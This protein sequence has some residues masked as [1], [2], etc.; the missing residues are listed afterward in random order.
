MK[1]S[2]LPAILL[3]LI[4]LLPLCAFADGIPV[5][6]FITSTKIP[7]EHQL[8]KEELPPMPTVE[9]TE[10]GYLLTGLSA[11]GVHKSAMVRY[12]FQVDGSALIDE[13]D[14]F[15]D[16]MLFTG[17]LDGL[18]NGVF[19]RLK[20]TSKYYDTVEISFITKPLEK[21][22]TDQDRI[23]MIQFIKKSKCSVQCYR[24]KHYNFTWQS[25]KEYGTATYDAEGILEDVYYNPKK[26]GKNSCTYSLF[27]RTDDLTGEPFYEL[28]LITD[29]DKQKALKKIPVTLVS[30]P[31]V[32]IK[33]PEGEN[34]DLQA[35]RSW[36][37]G[38][39]VSREDTVPQAFPFSGLT[40][41]DSPEV[42]CEYRDGEYVYTLKHLY[43]W[44]AR[45]SCLGLTYLAKDPKEA[46]DWFFAEDVESA[47][48]PEPGDTRLISRNENGTFDFYVTSE[49]EYINHLTMSGRAEKD[50]ETDEITG[51]QTEFTIHLDYTSPLTIRNIPGEDSVEKELTWQPDDNHTIVA[52]YR[53]DLLAGYTAS[54]VENSAIYRWGVDIPDPSDPGTAVYRYVTFSD[55]NK[56]VRKGFSP[57]P[58]G[59]G[60]QTWSTEPDFV[61]EPC[62]APDFL[63]SC[64]LYPI[65]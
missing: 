13:S 40:P 5:P 62:E 15:T 32:A 12:I 1:K 4:L 46:T 58:D 30:D 37:E 17:N 35:D 23:W 36:L 52:V 8:F 64:P 49:L 45:A 44:G 43:L 21:G 63:E 65:V 29:G 54:C 22:E 51:V 31:P 34:P 3:S 14:N 55:W 48:R 26:Q 28:R 2:L 6:N 24:D 33:M 56:N 9:K 61:S 39:L 47:F 42:L 10:E 7:V 16:S 50:P 27:R 20:S 19:L 38:L 18:E 53:N 57:A 25:N 59:T 11:W 41:G 60:W